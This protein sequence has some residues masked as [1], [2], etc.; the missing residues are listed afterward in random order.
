MF[1]LQSRDQ[2]LIKN[3]IGLFDAIERIDFWKSS[4]GK[5]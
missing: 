3:A 4:D 1:G 2:T 5:L